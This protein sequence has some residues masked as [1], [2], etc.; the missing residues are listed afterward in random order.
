MHV[1][2]IEWDTFFWYMCV[3]AGRPRQDL[4]S[5]VVK[6][7]NTHTLT[8]MCVWERM[9]IYIYIYVYACWPEDRPCDGLRFFLVV[10]LNTST[11]T[12]THAWVCGKESVNI[13]ISLYLSLFFSF[14]ERVCVYLKTNLG[15]TCA[16]WRE[17][18]K[19]THAHVC[20]RESKYICI[21]MYVCVWVCLPEDRPRDDLRFFWV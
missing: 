12:Y 18:G 1:C 6:M 21:C 17:Y 10:T 20:V 19:Y 7:V 2:V 13:H 8:C 3:P 14:F 9:S 11:W 16:F 4:R 15:T 5:L